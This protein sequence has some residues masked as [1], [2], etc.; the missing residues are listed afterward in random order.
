MK[1]LYGCLLICGAVVLLILLV[2]AATPAGQLLV[3]SLF[4]D[5]RG[6]FDKPRFEAV[7]KEVQRRG[8]KPGERLKL[9]LDRMDD[10]GSLRPQRTEDRDRGA[11]SG[12]VFAIRKPGG[13]L[14]VVI[15]TKDLGHAGEYG[16][17]YSE[18]HPAHQGYNNLFRLDAEENLSCTDPDWEVERNW[19]KVQACNW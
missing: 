12:N 13:E 5:R 7:V 14:I 1:K 11:G 19:W 8:L 3:L 6:P 16:Y 18:T 10:P 17:A 2:C 4:E 9:H 15:E